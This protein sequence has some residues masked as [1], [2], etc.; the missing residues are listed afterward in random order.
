MAALAR[1]ESKLSSLA[2][3]HSLH[4]HAAKVVDDLFRGSDFFDRRDLLQVKYEMLRRVRVEGASVTETA[5]AFGLSRPS[6]YEAQTA[7]AHDGLLGLLPKKRGPRRAYKMSAAVLAFLREQLAAD[8]SLRAPELARRLH[9]RFGLTVHPRS[10][11]RALSRE[12]K[13]PRTPGTGGP[14]PTRPRCPK[15]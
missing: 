12:G 3:R 15:R 2:R 8:A 9:E 13:A 14:A 10:I 1:Q 11:E 5:A 4:P 7:F 6:Y